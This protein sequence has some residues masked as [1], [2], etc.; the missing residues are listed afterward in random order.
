MKRLFVLMVLFMLVFSFSATAQNV[1]EII[2]AF[3][4]FADDAAPSIPMLADVGLRWS[5]AYIGGFPHF[6][7]GA[8]V[9]FVVVPMDDVDGFFTTLGVTDIPE[10]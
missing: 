2:G 6:G 3:E 7:V 1:D 9:G 4:D 8:T 10:E 5:D